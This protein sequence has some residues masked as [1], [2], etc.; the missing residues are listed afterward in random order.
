MPRC[1]K[2]DSIV[3]NPPRALKEGNPEKIAQMPHSRHG[4]L[5]AYMPA[6]GYCYQKR[7]QFDVEAT[8]PT[9]VYQLRHFGDFA[10]VLEAASGCDIRRW[11]R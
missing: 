4:I 9:D 7:G 6:D 3:R 5:L 8:L 1:V 11:L 10:D 2:T